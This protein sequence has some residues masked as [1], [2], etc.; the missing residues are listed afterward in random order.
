MR[1]LGTCMRCSA[2][3]YSSELLSGTRKLLSPYAALL[4]RRA[5][6]VHLA[7]V[8]GVAGAPLCLEIDEARMADQ[9]LVARGR[10]LQPV[11]EVPAITCAAGTLPGAVDERE[12]LDGGVGGL[13]DLIGRALQRIALDGARELLAEPGGPRVVS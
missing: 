9:A 4:P 13:V 3:Q 10:G 11:R 6:E 5:A 12:C 8:D 7:R 2:L 1:R